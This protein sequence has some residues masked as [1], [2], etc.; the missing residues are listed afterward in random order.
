MSERNWS[1][2][3]KLQDA[4]AEEDDRR[5]LEYQQRIK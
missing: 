2:L 1:R 3:L 4:C 5:T